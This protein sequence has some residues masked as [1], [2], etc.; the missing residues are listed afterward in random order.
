MSRVGR[1][2]IEVPAGLN[3]TITKTT[4]SVKGPKGELSFSY[5][6]DITVEQEDGVIKVLRPTDH[7]EHRSLHGL[8]RALINSAIVGVSQGFTKTLELH[9]VGYRAAMKGSN[10]ELSL[11]YSHPVV[12]TPPEGITVQVEGQNRVHVSGCDKQQV[13]QVAADIRFFRRPEPYKGKG[14][15]YAGERVRMKAGKSGKK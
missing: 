1:K 11:G 14:V 5:H 7:R 3:C 9:G 12:Y 13:G 8:T 6:P 2:L 10:L 15:R 4:F